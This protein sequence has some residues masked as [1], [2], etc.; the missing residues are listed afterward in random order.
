MMTIKSVWRVCA[1]TMLVGMCAVGCSDDLELQDDVDVEDDAGVDVSDSGDAGDPGNW[2]CSGEPCVIEDP[3]LPVRPQAGIDPEGGSAP[4]TPPA[5]GEWGLWRVGAEG[6]GFEGIWSHCREGDFM[7]G[8]AEVRVCIQGVSTNRYET[9][10]G[11]KL[12]DAHRVGQQGE[13]VLDMV[14]PMVGFGT[15]TA[16]RVEVV[17]DGS[18]GGVAVLRVTGTDVEL[19]HLA[20]VIGQRF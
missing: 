20:G 16:D 11:G 13:D 7:L 5:E 19:A 17:R 8:N 6:T 18:D 10:T 15:V 9:F 2:A 14:M 3:Y 4:A 12:V 1:A